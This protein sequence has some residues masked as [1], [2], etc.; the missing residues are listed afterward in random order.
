MSGTDSRVSASAFAAAVKIFDPAAARPSALAPWSHSRRVKLLWR[1]CF[2]T[3][4][5][6][7]IDE[8]HGNIIA[9]RCCT[10]SK[11]TIA[12]PSTSLDRNLIPGYVG[13]HDGRFA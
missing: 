4:R 9:G 5:F 1:I 10:P 8:R 13:F 7:S 3:G 12:V 6:D 2:P 11:N